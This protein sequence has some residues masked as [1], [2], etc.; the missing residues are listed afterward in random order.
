M[1]RLAACELLTVDARRICL[2]KPSALGDVVQTLPLLPVLRE[3][4][5]RASVSWVISDS[6]AG[7]LEGHPLLDELICFRRRGSLTE[8]L[9]LLGELRRREFDLVF[10]LQGLARTA[11]MT[12]ATR[13]DLRVGLETAREGAQMA[14]NCVIP[15]TGRYVPAHLRYWRVAQAIGAGH[16]RPRTT[17]PLRRK[18]RDWVAEKLAGVT[19]PVLAIHPGARWETKRWPVDR[20]AA[21][22]AKAKRAFGFTL[23]VLGSPAERA[24]AVKLE[25]LVKRFVPSATVLNLAGQTTLKQLA[26]MLQRAD[27]LLSNDSGP[28]HLA[29]GMGTPVVGV[30]TC[31]SPL[32]S[33]PPGELHELVA[34]T[35]AC[36]AS[37]RKRCPYRGSKH[38]ACMQELE[39]GRV[40]DGLV[41]VTRRLAH[42]SRAA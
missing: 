14:A 15:D 12:A 39:V 24:L 13:A 32:R 1:S 36:A 10:D 19:G 26:A 7:L 3:R 29:A 20:F 2:I 35:V 31:T 25:Y 6:L 37:Y 23:V 22:A 27:V 5:P 28:M 11:L 42:D 17:I 38:L 4:F 21:V 33:G 9:R 40:W 34:T 30:F 18:D 16:L 41:R 8:W